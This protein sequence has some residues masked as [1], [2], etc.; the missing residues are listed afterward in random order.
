MLH[1]FTPRLYQ[2]TIFATALNHNSLVVL[3][4]GMGKTA[5]AVMLALARLKSYPD[6]KV[7]FLAPTRP[8]VH[9]HKN[10]L[11]A[12][13]SFAESECVVFTGYVRPETRKQ[14]FDT[15]RIIFSTPQ[16]LEN[17][18]INKSISLANVSLIIFDEAHRAVGDYSYCFIAEAYS[19]QARYPRILGMTASPG[20]DAET[21]GE[22]MKNLF[23]EKIEVRSEEDSDVV[24]YVQ[25]TDLDWIS[26]VLPPEFESIRT[27]LL[28]CFNS[29]LEELQSKGIN[30]AGFNKTALLHLQSQILARVAKG[31]KD[32]ELLKS[33]S[34]AAEAMKVQHAIELAETQGISALNEYFH[35]LVVQARTTKVKAVQN[36]VKDLNFLSAKS[37]TESLH[38][39]GVE[40]PKLYRLAELVETSDAA[41]IIIFSQYR[42]QADTITRHLSDKGI[43]SRLF[44][45]QQ[46]KKNTGLSQKRQQEMLEDFRNGKFRCLVATSV[47]EEGLDIPKVDL[48]I[49][50]E[51]VPSAIRTIQ[52]RGRTGRLE[53]GKVIVLI[54]KGTRDESY[55]WA[56]HHKEKR[57]FRTLKN[58]KSSF[59]NIGELLPEKSTGQGTLADYSGVKIITDFREK[60]TYLLKELMALGADVKM[61]RLNVGDYLLSDK[62]CVEIKK[63]AD[64]VDSIIDGRLISQMKDLRQYDFPLVIVEGEEDIYAQ[65]KIHPNAIRGMIARIMFGFQIPILHTQSPR[66]T[67]AHLF[68]IAKQEQFPDPK[69]QYHQ[70]KPFT[71]KQQQEFIASTLPGIGKVLAKPLLERFKSIRALF[72]ASEEELRQVEQIGPV[73]AKKIREVLDSE[74]VG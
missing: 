22:V 30:T 66:E 58:I 45:G 24:E 54:T 9:Q 27:W 34:L 17:D 14:L 11:L 48:V 63:V 26:V 49:F 50:Y 73:K 39:K 40:H 31:E 53:K 18:I 47:A 3:P 42:D 29:K 21:I 15:S 43:S 36:L 10:S 70:S 44:V 60:N 62:V 37:L 5:I 61:Q 32:F 6:S 23:L 57:M 13:T 38:E 4:T 33:L 71:L 35:K 67:A 41:K 51:P 28:A 59:S 68:I 25:Q 46:K 65:R 1:N 8:L 2:E 56:A 12:M 19:S 74:Y 7:I 69:W 20:S 64:F 52:R 16:G 72:N 55:R